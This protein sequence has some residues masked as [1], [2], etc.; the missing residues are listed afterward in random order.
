MFISVYID[1]LSGTKDAT[2][3][4]MGCTLETLGFS[5]V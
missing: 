5:L 4:H 2:Q 1:L 3:K